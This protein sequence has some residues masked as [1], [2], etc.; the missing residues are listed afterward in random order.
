MFRGSVSWGRNLLEL[1]KSV[2]V[3][4]KLVQIPCK[5]RRTNLRK[6]NV[7]EDDS[8]ALTA[9]FRLSIIPNLKAPIMDLLTKLV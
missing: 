1:S 3:V 5:S 6:R 9:K 8:K 2:M 4:L 7:T